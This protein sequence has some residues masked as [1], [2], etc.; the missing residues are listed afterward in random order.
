MVPQSA[1][2]AGNL[3]KKKKKREEERG[4]DLVK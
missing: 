3:V 4:L 1:R 2:M